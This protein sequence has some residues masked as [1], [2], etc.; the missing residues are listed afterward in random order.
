MWGWMW[1]VRTFP[2][3]ITADTLQ[4]GCVDSRLEHRHCLAN[5]CLSNKQSLTISIN[6][7]ND[8]QDQ[9]L[10]TSMCFWCKYAML[11]LI[12]KVF[13]FFLYIWFLYHL[14]KFCSFVRLLS[15]L[16]GLNTANVMWNTNQSINQSINQSLR[17]LS[18]PL[19]CRYCLITPLP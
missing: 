12:Q 8:R 18:I 16:N 14:Q 15:Q 4:T 6:S 3:W 2:L 5:L 11:N 17:L 1:M 10:V 9:T 13:Y 19:F 7:V